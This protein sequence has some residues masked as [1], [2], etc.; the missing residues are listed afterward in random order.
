[1]NI[2][3]GMTGEPMNIEQ[4]MTIEEVRTFKRV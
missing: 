2:E 4:R 1:M 3:Y